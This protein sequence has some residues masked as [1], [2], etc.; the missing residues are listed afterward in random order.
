MRRT[1]GLKC[2]LLLNGISTESE[3]T[4]LCTSDKM[5]VFANKKYDLYT[6]YE[7]CE[8]FTFLMENE[9][10]QFDGMAYQRIV[11]IPMGAVLKLQPTFFLYCYERH[12]M[13]NLQKS[14]RFNLIDKFNDTSRYLDEIFTIDNPEFAEHIPDIFQ[15]VLQSDKKHLVFLGFKYKSYY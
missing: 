3:K 10:V 13:S 14:K 2:C 9:Y 1:Y 6:C 4:S 12:F 11:G 15:K 8:A 5:G 7:L